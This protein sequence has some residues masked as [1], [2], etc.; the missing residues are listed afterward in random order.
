M[1]MKVNNANWEARMFIKVNN[2]NWEA[3]MFIKV[4]DTHRCS[5]T[6]KEMNSFYKYVETFSSSA[7]ILTSTSTIMWSEMD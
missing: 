2:A 6:A 1:F 5:N 3:R 7:H 4:N